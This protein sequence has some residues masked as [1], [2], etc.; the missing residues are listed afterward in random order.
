PTYW[1]YTTLVLIVFLLKPSWVNRLQGNQV[2]VVASFF[3]IPSETLP[4]VIVGWSLVHEMYFYLVF[5]LILLLVPER[6]LAIALLSWSLGV[7]ILNFHPD[8]NSPTVSVIR[9]PLTFE[10]IGGCFLAIHFHGHRAGMNSRLL[11]LL[12]A[13]ALIC[14]LSAYFVYERMTG[15]QFPEDPWRSIIFGIPSLLTVYCLTNLEREG[16]RVHSFLARL[17]DASY[18][19][20][21][22]HV[23]IMS[24]A[25]RVWQRVAADGVLDNLIMAPAL[26]ILA[27]V[28]GM[29]SHVFIERPLLVWSRQWV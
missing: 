17:G 25:G 6:R 20:Y 5:F 13:T 12:A 3:L 7:V 9:H 4:L 14:A 26:L 2:D 29:I 27:L 10:F 19:I 23:L 8:L 1:L 21:L 22:S 24:A 18:S 16:C 15:L 28:G 11:R